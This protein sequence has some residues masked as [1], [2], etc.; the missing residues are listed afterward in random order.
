MRTKLLTI[1]LALCC[2]V[3]LALT[4]PPTPKKKKPQPATSAAPSKPKPQHKP[5]AKPKPQPKPK[6]TSHTQPQAATVSGP[7]A[8]LSSEDRRVVEGIYNNMVLVEGGT[9]YMGATSEQ[10]SDAFSYEEPAHSVTLSSYRIGR[11]E[12]TQR[13]WQAVMGSNPSYF[14]GDLDCPVEQVDYDMCLTFISKLN[15]LT[16]K[17]YRLPTEAEW[18]FAARGGTRSQGDKYSGSNSLASVAWYDDNSSSTT[19][20]VGSLSPNELGLYDMSGNVWEWCADW[21]G[22]YSSNDQ[23]NPTGPTS[24]SSRVARGGSWGS[25]AGYCRVSYRIN[26]V[27]S[28]RNYYLGLRL[29]L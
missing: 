2:S 22:S 25:S 29:V 15:N 12:V 14:K 18:E 1:L 21:Y 8:S 9:F 7:M 20:R 4:P 24:G 5:M 27:P 13:E 26:C 17:H 6:P 10:G 28:Y 3:A 23:T 16:G 19:H 11:Y